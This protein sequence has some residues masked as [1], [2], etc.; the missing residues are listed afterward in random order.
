MAVNKNAA[1]YATVGS[2]KEFWNVWRERDDSDDEVRAC[3]NKTLD[4]TQKD[5]LF[6]GEFAG[7]RAHFSELETDGGREITEQDKCIF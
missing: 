1:K 4:R 3:V 6:A 2:G 5:A 7:A